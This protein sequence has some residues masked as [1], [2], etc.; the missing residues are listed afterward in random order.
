MAGALVIVGQL[1]TKPARDRQASLRRA[2]AYTGEESTSNDPLLDRLNERYSGRLATLPAGS[3]HVRPRTRS[4]STS[5]RQDWRGASPGRSLATKVV[6]GAVGIA[7]G[8]LLGALTGSPM[9]ALLVGIAGGA[10]GFFGPDIVVT[11]RTRKRET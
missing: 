7:I 4:G 5:S 2:G 3:I 10:F 11:S 8:A 6:L 9:K 1:V